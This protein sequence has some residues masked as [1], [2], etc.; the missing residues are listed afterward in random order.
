MDWF[1]VLP[2]RRGMML[3]AGA[4]VVP[5]LTVGGLLTLGGG[6]GKVSSSSPP[7]PKNH[8]PVEAAVPPAPTFGAYVPPRRVKAS[9][10]AESRKNATSSTHR[11]K[12]GSHPSATAT[13]PA[14]LKRWPWM[15][16]LCRQQNHS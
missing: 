16:E 9:H 14:S 13:C 5:A 15:W 11:K 1:E 3:L 8:A 6:S 4:V 2:F 10:P 12:P 7:A